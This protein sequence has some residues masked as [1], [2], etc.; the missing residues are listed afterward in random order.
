MSTF[1]DGLPISHKDSDSQSE[2]LVLYNSKEALPADH[3]TAA[4]FH[5]GSAPPMLSASDATAN[6]DSLK[7]VVMGKTMMT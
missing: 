6:C 5:D 4:R 1:D 7:V 3:D 2:V